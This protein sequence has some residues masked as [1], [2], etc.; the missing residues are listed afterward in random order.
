MNA[1]V[2]PPSR[3]RGAGPLSASCAWPAPDS[4][5]TDSD[6]RPREWSCQPG[7]PA[8]VAEV[9]RSTCEVMQMPKT[10]TPT[11]TFDFAREAL[12]DRMLE[13]PLAQEII[14]ELTAEKLAARNEARQL[15]NETRARI[16]ALTPK[17]DQ[18][19]EQARAD[20]IPARRGLREALDAVNRA[21]KRR[22]DELAQLF[23]TEQQAERIL[24]AAQPASLRRVRLALE[25][26]RQALASLPRRNG[27]QGVQLACLR[28][29]L[30]YLQSADL[31]DEKAID[32]LAAGSD[33]RLARR[34]RRYQALER[35]KGWRPTEPTSAYGITRD[36]ENR[37]NRR[38]AI[39][40][41]AIANVTNLD[42]GAGDF[43]K[44][45]KDATK[46]ASALVG[47]L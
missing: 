1:T 32:A 3:C 5:Q 24:R 37:T 6:I 4:T 31:L 42:P 33:E 15:I 30:Q 38:F 21:Q 12:L 44:A 22:R 8:L 35:L 18:D 14:A 36:H 7:M 27:E 28:D 45:F 34:R 11:P 16:E 2:L 43:D 46:A 41:A 26:E 29:E 40:R 25:R 9:S 17:L 20:V 10:L 13:S 23:D 47:A 39:V 19:I